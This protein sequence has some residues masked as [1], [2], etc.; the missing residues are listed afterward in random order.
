LHTFPK[1]IFSMAVAFHSGNEGMNSMVFFF[2]TP[3]GTA[4]TTLLA[5]AL[6]PF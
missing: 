5:D 4:I 1:P 2:S 6:N 3:R